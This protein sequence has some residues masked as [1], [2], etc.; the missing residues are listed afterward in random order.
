[1]F[2][3]TLYVRNARGCVSDT[4]RKRIMVF[5]N[6][7]A[8]FSSVQTICV[9]TPVPF[10]NNSRLGYGSTAF[11]QTLWDFGD[12]VISTAFNPTH[13]FQSEGTFTVSLIVNSDSSCVSSV[14]S[15]VIKVIGRAQ[16]D[17]SFNSNCVNQPVT[18]QNTT[19]TGFG[20]SHLHLYRYG[21]LPGAA[22][23]ERAVLR[24]VERYHR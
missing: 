16:A 24:A 9:G 10:I 23:R 1:L 4:I 7:T 8:D 13:T 11:S 15:R 20:E 21:H 17:F 3:P 14:T 22:D 5:G 19:R 6:P 12:G 2:W 18:F